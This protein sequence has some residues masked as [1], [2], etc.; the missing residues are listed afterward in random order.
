MDTFKTKFPK[1]IIINFKVLFITKNVI[2]NK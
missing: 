1:I 2:N